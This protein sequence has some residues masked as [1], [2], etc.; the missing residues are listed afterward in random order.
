MLEELSKV[1]TPYNSFDLLAKVGALRIDPRNASRGTSLNALAHLVAAQSYDASDPSISR[2]KLESLVRGYLGTDS[3]PWLLDDPSGQMFTEEIM[4]TG[5]PY[6]VF[7]G[8]LDGNVD[9]LRWLLDA[10]LLMD[11]SARLNTC[12][13]QVMQTAILCLSV[14]ASI[15]KKAG[16]TRGIPPAEDYKADIIVPM[17][18]DLRRKSE[19]VVFSRSQLIETLPAK[20]LL[21]PIIGP[22]TA[23]V[24]TV[25]WDAYTFDFGILDHTPF[26]RDD[27]RY[28]I[29]NPSAL[30]SGL[31]HR[32]LCIARDQN[33]LEDLTRA[34]HL[35]V[36]REITR[37]LRYWQSYPTNIPLPRPSQDRFS[38][39]VFSLDSDKIVYVQLATDSVADL[40]GQYDPSEWDTTQLNRDLEL[41]NTEV[42]QHLA[43]LGFAT[44]RF[45]TLSIV[46]ALGRSYAVGYA[47]PDDDSLLLVISANALKAVTLLDADDPLTLWKF[48]RSRRQIRDKAHVVALSPLDEYACYRSNHRGYYTGDGRRPSLINVVSGQGLDVRRRVAERFDFHGVLAPDGIY[49]TEVWSRFGDTIPI[50]GLPPSS[51]NQLA[52]VVEG[53][54][55]VPVWVIGAEQTDERLRS[56][57]VTLVNAVAYWLWQFDTVLGPCISSLVDDLHNFC[58]A[59]D[60][61]ASSQW[62][63]KMR[64]PLAEPLQNGPVIFSYART[65]AG[66]RLAIHSSLLVRSIVQGNEGERQLIKE[67]IGALQ[68]I[69]GFQ[70]QETWTPL[71]EADIDR[72]ID[73]IAPLGP[74]QMFLAMTDPILVD[75]LGRLSRC[76]VIQEADQQESLDKLGEHLRAKN[77]GQRNVAGKTKSTTLLNDSVKYFFEEIEK[78][79]ATLDGNDLLTKLVTYGENNTA[80]RVRRE[81]QIANRLACFG[82]STEPLAELVEDT[83]SQNA[84]SVANRFLVEYTVARPPTGA[85]RL[86]LEVYDCLLAMAGEV[87]TLGS[88][89]DFIKFGLVDFEVEML[90]SGRLGFDNSAFT[91][92]RENFMPNYVGAQASDAG[93]NLA[94]D[95]YAIDD[96]EPKTAQASS[97][98]ERFDEPFA[99]EFGISLTELLHLMD[100]ILGLA[101]DRDGPVSQLP[102]DHMASALTDSLGWEDDKVRFGIDMLSLG[103][104]NDFFDLPSG[105]KSDVYPWRFNRSWSYLRR[106][107]LRTGTE[108]D[109]PIM[110]GNRHLRFSMAY[111]TDLCVGGRL[112]ADTKALQRVV[113]ERRQS[114]AASFEETVRVLVSKIT[115]TEAKGRLRKVGKQRISLGGADLGDI[116]VVGVIPSKRVI[117]CIECKA[118]ALARTPTEIQNQVEELTGKDGKAGSVQKHHKRVKWVEEHLDQVLKECFSI[119]RKG[120][121]QVKPI[122]V[123]DREL[124]APHI[125]RIPFPALSIESLRRMSPWEIAL[126]V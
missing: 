46:E 34:Y 49:L 104:R 111:I 56:L 124:F 44:D 39:A 98:V 116:D 83:L 74:K 72:A 115:G 15:A 53:E 11:T 57:L 63:D 114:K 108:T 45:L 122:L 96:E 12:R 95:G 41:R 55:P 38:E 110:W 97:I 3:V 13:D 79:L 31:R 61:H 52:L 107:L 17:G 59:L 9:T 48:A 23:D 42:L 16:L 19:A 109:S 112:K 106:P 71:C 50:Y 64:N 27:D 69:I 86:S 14:S 102:A 126:K 22:L 32:I 99:E 105:S 58:V 118:L 1:L 8:L 40:N 21:G 62:L 24:G 37:L 100:A 120:R 77:L 76:R 28:V 29:P 94:S 66:V 25:E 90:P 125:K 75:D 70:C 18:E 6:V 47:S 82:D 89:S 113:G 4:L 60:L 92:A 51:G 78:L 117:L 101:I 36:H 54:F 7:P 119:D 93:G 91:A 2:H 85:R 65:E 5:G 73:A 35:V 20:T 81:V 68:A 103:P 26:V 43:G 33:V 67:M 30:L 84:S 123:S 87:V 80:E 10:A 88:M 121:W